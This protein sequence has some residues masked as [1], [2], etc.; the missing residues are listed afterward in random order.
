MSHFVVLVITPQK[1]S[2]DELNEVLLPWHE[3]ECTGIDRYIREIDQTD[4]LRADFAKDKT[5]VVRMPDGKLVEAYDPQFYRE[6]TPEEQA[7]IDA[8]KGKMFER[9][10]VPGAYQAD[11]D[12]G[13]GYRY[14]VRYVPEGCEAV[15]VPTSEIKTFAK[16]VEDNSGKKVVPFATSPD[17]REKHKYGWVEVD[18]NGDVTKV[19]D[20][21]NPDK[22]WDWW[23]LGG[24]WT[25][26]LDPL[27][28]AHK[29]PR[30]YRPCYICG[31][32]GMRMDE[33]GVEARLKDPTYTCNGCSEDAEDA[34]TKGWCM[35]HPSDW[36]DVGN[37]A[38][39]KDIPIA[40]IR[41]KAEKEAREEHRAAYA[42][43][44][45]ER[46]KP[47]VRKDGEDWAAE[48]DAFWEQPA[49][50]LLQKT[51][52][53]H[54]F[55]WLEAVNNLAL[56]EDEYAQQARNQAMCPFAF[57][58]EGKWYEKGEMGWFACVSDEKKPEDWQAIWARAFDQI[59]DDMWL[60]VCDCHI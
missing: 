20:R 25:S 36:R 34:P 40:A 45:D 46:I 15:E 14:K 57:V 58:F 11:W 31:G 10:E 26:F 9:P 8:I 28:E 3:F 1:P 33:L 27:Y 16:Y 7:K 24:R 56:T 44:G 55:M 38:Q 22:K 54:R 2:V 52:G 4:E 43:M 35:K 6:P 12:D 51:E 13:K 42:A 39:K 60:S 5:S 50:K 30:N 37:Q 21:T 23:K 41:D 47:W 17:L 18:E 48:R 32:T 53:G 49:V 29:D 19:I 59:A